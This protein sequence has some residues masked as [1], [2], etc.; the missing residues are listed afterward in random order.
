MPR[1]GESEQSDE[2]PGRT[3][4][5]QPGEGGSVLPSPGW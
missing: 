2:I 5:W 3:L 1:E 4:L